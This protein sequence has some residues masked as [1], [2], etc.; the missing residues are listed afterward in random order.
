MAN[1]IITY[2]GGVQPTTPE[3]GQQQMAKYMAWLG[4]L[5]DAAISPANPLKGTKTVNPDG[6][7]SNGGKT[8]MSGFTVVEADSMDAALALAKVCPFLEVGGSLEVSE[9]MQMQ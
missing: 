7:V 6:T 3:E 4:G 8:A 5:G 1:Y 2:L 9:L